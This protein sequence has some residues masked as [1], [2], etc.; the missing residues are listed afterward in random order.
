MAEG[1]RR[2]IATVLAANADLQFC[3]NFAASID[4]Y[5]D[6]LAYAQLIN[7]DERIGRKYAARGIDAEETR[8][9]IARNPEGGLGQVVGAE[10]K[11][12]GGL[13]NFA[14]HQGRTWQFDH[15]TDLITD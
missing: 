13:R 15:R 9:V 11:E 3:A 7:R 2:R 5:F 10:R 14:G 1:Y 6:Q 12:F 4:T 8:R